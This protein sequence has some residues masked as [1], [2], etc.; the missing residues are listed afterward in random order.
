MNEIG[1]N[2]REKEELKTV[3]RNEGIQEIQKKKKRKKV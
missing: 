3:G 2:K 1:F